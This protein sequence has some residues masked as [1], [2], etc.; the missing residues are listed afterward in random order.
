MTSAVAEDRR[1]QLRGVFPGEYAA[2]EV[3]QGF[4]LF[5]PAWRHEHGADLFPLLMLDV[6]GFAV[7]EGGLDALSECPPQLHDSHLGVLHVR[8]LAGVRNDHSVRYRWLGTQWMP[9]VHRARKAPPVTKKVPSDVVERLTQ[10]STFNPETGC[11][12]WNGA[13]LKG[14]GVLTLNGKARRVHIVAWEAANGPTPPGLEL[15]HRCHSENRC[16]LGDDCPHRACWNVT[17]LVPTS[18]YQNVLDGESPSAINA[19]KTHCIRNHPLSG[20]NLYVPPNRNA[21]VCRQCRTDW[22]NDNRGAYN[23]NRKAARAARKATP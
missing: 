12:T 17:H 18:H 19:R 20:P 5:D 14:Y 16:G 23:A 1:L 7:E 2:L 22:R 6:R 13:K 11:I 3:P 9:D 10:G 15:D 4:H 8:N 21:R